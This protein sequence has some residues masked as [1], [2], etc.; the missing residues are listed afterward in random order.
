MPRYSGRKST[1]ELYKKEKERVTGIVKRL[2]AKG[3]IVPESIIN[4]QAGDK[5]LM[6]DVKRLQA[7]TRE[8]IAKRSQIVVSKQEYKHIKGRGFYVTETT[9]IKGQDVNRELR[10]QAVRSAREK[11]EARMSGRYVIDPN[12]GY[13]Y[14]KE[15]G[16][17]TKATK[18]EIK[19]A[20]EEQE[21]AIPE[22]PADGGA[23]SGG[24]YA[25]PI[26]FGQQ[27]LNQYL[28]K[29]GMYTMDND[30]LIHTK[31]K[32]V[33]EM[34]RNANAIDSYI[35]KAI[36]QYGAQEVARIL[37][38]MASE[39]LD[40]TP[41]MLYDDDAM[42]MYLNEL[43]RQLPLDDRYDFELSRNDEEGAEEEDD[44]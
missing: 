2:E 20:K 29:L 27:F 39:G 28:N 13:K 38:S 17:V 15:T 14:D 33:K 36:D 21:R 40:I 3:V 44:E 32:F 5:I 23:G 9:V 41:K 22:L 37:E 19:R 4:K 16:E 25:E 12:T 31:S 1:I 26:D 18:G 6:K 43:D 42:E 34:A 24:G 11:R 8:S 30:E 35:G 10:K 7:M